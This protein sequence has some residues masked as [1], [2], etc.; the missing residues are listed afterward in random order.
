MS[1]LPRSGASRGGLG[2]D[3][4]RFLAA[5]ASSNLG[6]GIRLG[7]LPL[8]AISLTDDARLI[9]LTG[10]ATM[11]PWLLLGPLGG[12]LVDRGDRRMLMI[13]GQLVRA[14]AVTLLTVLVATETASIWWVI[15]IAFVLGAGEVV[16]DSSS[17]A[18]VPQL[19]G[20]DQLERAN[21]RLIAAMT[22]FDTVVGVALG[23]L[24]FSV[25][26]SLPFA[27]DAVTFVVGAALLLTIRRPLQGERT[28]KTTVRDDVAE[29]WR[30][31][32]GHR[33]L[34]GLMFAVATSNFAANV[35]M[36]VFVVLI[37][38][39]LGGSEASFGLVLGVGA[40]GGVLGSLTAARLVERFGRRPVLAMTPLI[41]SGAYLVNA[42][43]TAV[44]MPAAAFF[45][46][47]FAIICFN[48]PGQSLRQ[49]LT[50]EPL[51]GRVVATFRMVGM[52]AA[53]VGA[54]LGGF[55]TE[56]FDVRI[57]NVTAAGLQVLAWFVL[58]RALRHLTDGDNT[59]ARRPVETPESEPNGKNEQA[60]STPGTSAIAPPEH[61]DPGGVTDARP[62][63]GD[64][65][66]ATWP[67]PP[68]GQ[69]VPTH[70]VPQPSRQ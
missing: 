70:L 48:V 62:S 51:L 19:V 29:G 26:S 42:L 55:V 2:G 40:I 68:S 5:A 37:V 21:G 12:A 58:L 24:L 47:S 50:P 41:A 32:A 18:A 16:V 31:L 43:A 27:V 65:P 46:V 28:I 57:A 39:D 4:Q 30:F 8:L 69:Q 1:R 66:P 10:A 7:A 63:N 61:I 54:I 13:V 53:P 38:D 59:P 67:P 15:A 17:Q 52:G 36:G 56:A 20:P 25:A 33:L 22:L 6:D 34:R 45:V 14:I 23:A 64:A 9:G 44:W 60:S 11:L 49:S 35:S 3:F